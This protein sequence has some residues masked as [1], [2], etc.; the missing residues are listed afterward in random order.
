MDKIFP[1]SIRSGLRVFLL[2]GTAAALAGCVINPYIKSPTAPAAFSGD[3]CRRL[4]GLIVSA[5]TAAN[6]GSS[7]AENRGSVKDAMAYALCTQRAMERK[8]GK[9]AWMNQGGAIVLMHMAGLAGYSGTRGG[10][11]AQV[12][13]MTTGGATFY[14]A[15]QYLYH[16]PREATYWLGSE[17]LSCVIAVTN[18][19]LV[20]GSGKEAALDGLLQRGVEEPLGHLKTLSEVEPAQR[21]AAA[22]SASCTGADRQKLGQRLSELS[23]AVD[24][25]YAD[26]SLADL[27]QATSWSRLRL[28]ELSASSDAARADLID[29]TDAIRTAVGRQLAMQQPDPAGLAKLLGDQKLPALAGTP[30]P[31]AADAATTVKAMA[32]MTESVRVSKSLAGTCA[33]DEKR[34]GDYER[35]VKNLIRRHIE[36][37]DGLVRFAQEYDLAKQS[38]AATTDDARPIEQCLH[39]RGNAL[40]PFRLVLAQA[41]PVKVAK[42][43]SQKIAI[44]GGVAPF[45]IESLTDGGKLGVEA[46]TAATGG[47]EIVVTAAA[48]AAVDGKKFKYFVADSA[49]GSD[50]FTV[51]IV[52]AP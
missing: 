38:V 9:Y 21:A 25:A 19:R 39:L 51:E 13:A 35:T 8:A 17:A 43:G 30:K 7:D 4:K 11:N 20:N 2:T 28:K 49:G 29:T 31:K 27:Y 40:G 1:R 33:A 37:R 15:Q 22:I 34:V 42:G 48:D 14:A 18:R 12:A 32:P 52:A 6:Q 16:K 23:E 26:A 10:H 45:R 44:E 36:V 50:L 5:D 47:Y 3:E 46:K 24:S 41:G